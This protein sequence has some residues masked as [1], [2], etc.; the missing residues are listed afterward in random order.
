MASSHIQ[1]AR[2]SYGF[3]L[4]GLVLL[5]L[6]LQAVALAQ[7]PGG[8]SLPETVSWTVSAP[9]ADVRPGSRV[10]VTL[11]GE[12]LEGWHVYG[13]QQ[14]PDGP[15]PLRITL[16]ANEVVVADGAPA[17]S[18]AI[19]YHDPSFNLDT[20]YYTKPFSVTLPVRIA[21]GAPAGPLQIPVSV[22]FQTCNGPTCRPPKTVHL[23]API[24]VRTGG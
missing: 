14:E 11:R 19:K 24:T 6:T 18:P 15:T 23:V 16:D 9:S 5:A 4:L 13:L 1:R 10:T 20:Q 8:S 22:R 3:V 2:K 17:G 12:V 21:S 7:T